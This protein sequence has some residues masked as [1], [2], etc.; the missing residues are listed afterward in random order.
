MSLHERVESKHNLELAFRECRDKSV[1]GELFVAFFDG[2]RIKKVNDTYGHIM[3]DKVIERM[4]AVIIE[5]IREEDRLIR[6]GGDEFVLFL[7]NFNKSKIKSF[8]KRI[9]DSIRQDEFLIKSVKGITA[10]VGV[11]EYQEDIH[12]TLSNILE[13]ADALMYKAKHNPPRYCVFSG[14]EV[15]APEKKTQRA[16]DLK[17]VRK[18]AYFDWVISMI[19][20]EH[21][22]YNLDVITKIAREIWAIN[23]NKVID[24]I[25]PTTAVNMIIATYKREYRSIARSFIK[26]RMKDLN[27][28]AIS[29][30]HKKG[31]GDVA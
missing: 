26:R 27:K 16:D 18:R 22:E 24:L 21:P 1:E 25:T 15:E 11:I 7:T 4:S 8:I 17:A 2:N 29:Q 23:G 13:E 20:H 14:D 3:G 30:F 28:E 19:V 10:S 9:Q 5:N 12:M 31:R 6:F